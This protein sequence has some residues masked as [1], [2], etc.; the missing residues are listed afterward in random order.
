[1]PVGKI[2]ILRA[3][4]ADLVDGLTTT[5]VRSPFGEDGWRALRG[6]NGGDLHV[7]AL[8]GGALVVPFGAF[9][10]AGDVAL[11]VRGLLGAALDRHDDERGLFI[12]SGDAPP[13]GSYEAAVTGEGGFVPVPA[14]DDPRLSKDAGWSFAAAARTLSAPDAKKRAEERAEV[15]PF[16]SAKATFDQKLAAREDR[17]NLRRTL[18]AA[19][20]HEVEHSA[21]GQAA[22]GEEGEHVE[23]EA[24]DRLRRALAATPDRVTELEGALRAAVDTEIAREEEL[25]PAAAPPKAEA[26]EGA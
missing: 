8:E 14:A 3:S 2:A 1:M 23:G 22:S 20:N 10:S 16:A 24:A 9:E 18:S 21:L 5:E 25:D 12:A 7:G 17:G 19:L 26:D 13:T 15:D 6:V 11:A 4:V